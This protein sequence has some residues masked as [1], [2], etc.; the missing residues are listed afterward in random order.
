MDDHFGEL[1]AVFNLKHSMEVLT[2]LADERELRFSEI[3]RQIGASSDVTTRVLD[4][5]CE[6]GLLTRQESN[7]RTVHYAIT[8]SGERFLVTA[9]ELE[10]ELEE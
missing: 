10:A 3:E 2:L 7:P 6:Q 9:R 1:Y 4:Q 8:D 5:L